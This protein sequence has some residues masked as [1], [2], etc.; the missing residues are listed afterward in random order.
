MTGS[1]GLEG[2]DCVVTAWNRCDKAMVLGWRRTPDRLFT[3]N[4]CRCSEQTCQVCLGRGT[5]RNVSPNLKKGAV[6]VT[7]HFQHG[8]CMVNF[9]LL[10]AVVKKG[11]C[12]CFSLH[13]PHARNCQSRL[14]CSKQRHYHGNF[15]ATGTL[16]A[17]RYALA[18]RPQFLH[19]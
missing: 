12:G 17:W 10:G 4:N 11:L 6:L 13:G 14:H 3:N 19:L 8:G 1:F 7:V 5:N 16:C 15:P 2:F 18:K 9:F